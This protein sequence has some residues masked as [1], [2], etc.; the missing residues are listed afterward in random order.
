MTGRGGY[1][2]VCSVGEMLMTERRYYLCRVRFRGDVVFVVWYSDDRDGF[3]RDGGGRLVVGRSPKTIAT[4]T[5]LEDEPTDYD[6]DRLQA[7]C[8]VPSAADV[9][10]RTFLNAWNFFDDLAGLHNGGES[11]YIQLS[12]EASACYDKLFWG[13]NLLAITPSGERYVPTWN[14]EELAE[15]RRVMVESLRLFEAELRAAEGTQ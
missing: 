4:P 14:E 8:T 3:L 6:F 12:R 7:W 13:N 9:D 11:T 15:M 10:C 2:V 5:P 1:L